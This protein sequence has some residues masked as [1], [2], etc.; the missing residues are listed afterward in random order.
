MASIVLDTGPFADFL[1]QYFGPAQ[2]G[3]LPFIGGWSLSEKAA[4]SINRIVRSFQAEE[5]AR[6]LV[7]AST[8]AFV[9]VARK[10]D[11][12]AD[13]RFQAY[14]L[15]AFLEAPPGWFS[16]DP[17]DE[18]LVEFFFRLPASVLMESGKPESIEWT[19][20]VHAATTLSHDT[21]H[22]RCLLAVE[23]QRI[24]RIELLSDVWV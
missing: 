21:S 23:D 5:P 12:L 9:E 15:R 7:I 4:G 2:R 3:L 18:D 10:W 20:A 24:R 13:G 16:V 1:G 8:F 19:D 17:V 22:T 6:Y 14:Q 11:R